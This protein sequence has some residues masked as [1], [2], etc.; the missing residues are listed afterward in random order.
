LTV[1]KEQPGYILV[2]CTNGATYFA[3][4]YLGPHCRIWR[5]LIGTWPTGTRE[6]DRLIHPRNLPACAREY[7]R[8]HLLP[9]PQETA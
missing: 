3:S 4:R 5:T 1:E 9:S 7:F 2:R 8:A 6:P